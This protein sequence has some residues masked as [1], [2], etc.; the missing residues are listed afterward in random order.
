MNVRLQVSASGNGPY[1]LEKI[2][3]FKVAYYNNHIIP[4]EE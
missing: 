2:E 1:Y 3:L 4:I